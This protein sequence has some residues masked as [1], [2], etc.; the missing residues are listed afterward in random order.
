MS[1]EGPTGELVLT[2]WCSVMHHINPWGETLHG[3][4]MATLRPS[5]MRNNK[6][7][8]PFVSHAAPVP[9]DVSVNPRKDLPISCQLL[10][11]LRSLQNRAQHPQIHGVPRKLIEL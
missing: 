10:L 3:F 11:L 9:G 4:E 7:P 6:Q 8:A 5:E 2:Q 1:R